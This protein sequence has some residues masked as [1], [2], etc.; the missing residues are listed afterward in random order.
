MTLPGFIPS[1]ISKYIFSIGIILFIFLA[2]TSV[3]LAQEQEENSELPEPIDITASTIT[4]NQNSGI[5][6][7]SGD[8]ELSYKGHK[9]SCEE[10][11]FDTVHDNLTAR[12]NVDWQYKTW[13]VKGEKV[14]YDFMADSGVFVNARSEFA[15]WH[16]YGEQIIRSG[17]NE[18]VLINGWVSTCDLFSP[19]WRVSS[20]RITVTLDDAIRAWN[21]STYIGKIPVFW[22][23]Y[24]S[25]SLKE[26]RSR[27]SAHLGSNSELGY[28]VKARYSW[29]WGQYNDGVAHV[30]YMTKK[31]VGIGF[32]ARCKKKDILNSLGQVYWVQEK[33]TKKDQ[34]RVNLKHY[35][36]W[37]DKL[38]LS[39]EAQYITSQTLN[40][41]FLRDSASIPKPSYLQSRAGLTWSSRYQTARLFVSSRQDWDE[42]LSKYCTTAETMPGMLWILQPRPLGI[43]KWLYSARVEGGRDYEQDTKSR[44]WRG[45]ANSAIETTYHLPA[46]F[47][48]NPKFTIDKQW[49]ESSGYPAE[50]DATVS[51]SWR[52]T[53][54][55]ELRPGYQYVWT[56]QN[57]VLGNAARVALIIRPSHP[58]FL[59]T[60]SG[61]NLL[62]K[63]WDNVETRL[64]GRGAGNSWS[65]KHILDTRVM[66]TE[67]GELGVSVLTAKN[68]KVQSNIR[69]LAE[70]PGHMDINASVQCPVGSKLLLDVSHRFQVPD[71]RWQER[72]TSIFLTRDLHCWWGKF[73]WERKWRSED[74]GC[75]NTIW[76]LFSIKAFPEQEIGAS[77]ETEF[78]QIR[79]HTSS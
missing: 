77:Y 71:G 17:T 78:N 36:K 19:H 53:R 3:I 10:L 73:G 55:M 18:M 45:S 34:F 26:R 67:L 35:Q 63:R 64:S 31:G 68:V 4:Y 65:M 49:R 57:D 21:T 41:I 60:K 25:R 46:N 32:D 42:E 75:D 6:M 5:L 56:A 51:G 7:A 76:L 13:A 29:P 11:N 37:T 58:L 28:F 27:W 70:L 50:Y 23:P 62:N 12:G 79:F 43:L 48:V 22:V 9:F 52:F 74:T 54:R 44:Y 30:D 16:C 61:Y 66:T 1:N 15:P 72:E 40:Y 14:R 47:A 69:Y 24:F 8:V 59:E 38:S 39:G 2:N 20:D 33:D